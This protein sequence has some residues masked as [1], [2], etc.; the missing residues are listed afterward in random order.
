MTQAVSDAWTLPWR[1]LGLSSNL[2]A[3]D[4]PHP[5]RLLDASPGLFDFVEYSAP[6][7]LDEAREHASL[8]PE[9]WRRRA[10]VPVLFHPVH[11]NLWGPELEPASALAALDAHAREV[12]S[13]WVGNDVGW[14]H[15]QGQ[16]FPGYLYFTPPFNEAGLADCVAHALHV[17]SHLSVPLVV[18]NPAVLARRGEWHA[19]D[20]LARLH[21]RTGL[22]LLLDLGH[23]FSHQLSAGLPLEAGFDTFPLDQV[24]EIHIAGGVVTRRGG[25]AFYVDDHTQPVREELFQL[26]ESLL[27]RCPSLRAV[28]F[29]GDGHSPEVAELS[30]RRL[31]ALVPRGERPP[32]RLR[33]PEKVTP[34]ALT[35][36]GR[37]WELFDAGHGAAPVDSVEDAAGT[38]AD[39]DF[40]LAVI[41]E[42]LDK[43]WPLSRLLLAGTRE[44]LLAF[45]A[46]REYRN[47]F[48]GLGR[49]LGQAFSVWA[50]RRLREQPD[51]GAS[52]AL[53][54]EM[55]APTAFM[56]P[57]P[58]PGPGQVG[59]AEDVRPGIL[60][61]NL[62][63]LVFAAR[64]VRRH[65]TG[66]AWASGALE[67]S[68]LESL[69]QAARRY[70][71]G[72][73]TF[74][75]RRKATGHE[76]VTGTRALM[77][78]LK[79]LAARPRPVG[80]VPPEALAEGLGR[81]LIRQGDGAGVDRTLAPVRPVG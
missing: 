13:A 64:A 10:E 35:G 41:A 12:G 56:R 57:V 36:G 40:R 73:W 43:D 19:L 2:S 75:V 78:L 59:L 9:M 66:R 34:P 29:E 76:V 71:A 81:G 55:L 51:E 4:V 72:P 30:L 54:L 42:A 32:L 45:T 11:L 6:L 49:T 7:S 69:G 61:A 24:V 46:S 48:T 8:F 68:G 27:P 1:G 38:L 63:E 18:E 77:D 58:P 52:A 3:A 14:W 53:S 39:Q 22:P 15:S 21:A 80:E 5:Y 16:P 20:F 28:T 70:G 65:L 44:Q 25:R 23:L 74:A 47:L 50:M 62:T 33:P 26:L 17:Q 67:L 31:R 60:P 37:P 79:S